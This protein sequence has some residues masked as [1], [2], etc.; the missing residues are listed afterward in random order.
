MEA[1]AFLLAGSYLFCF[2]GVIGLLAR[3]GGQTRRIDE[4]TR[5]IGLLK[6]ELRV[7]KAEPGETQTIEV[8]KTAEITPEAVRPAETVELPPQDAAASPEIAEKPT[9]PSPALESLTRFVRGG[10]LWAA[11]GILLLTAAF[12]LL[13]TYLARRGFFTVEMGIAAAALSGLAMLF[14][15]WRFRKRRALYFLL[16]QGGGIGILYL[17][18]FAAHKLTP[19]FPHV[20]ALILLSL[21]VAPAAILALLQNSQAL[22]V[23]GTAGGF[24]APLLL[25]GGSGNHVFLFAYYLALDAGVLAIGLRRLW[26]WLD[27]LSLAATF[28]VSL[29]W[30]FVEY[31]AGLFWTVEPFMLG[32][33]AVFTAL[34]L[35][36][37]GKDAPDS[38]DAALV[39]ATPIVGAAAQWR[40]FSF[41]PHGHAIICVAFAAAYLALAAGVWRCRGKFEGEKARPFA[42]GYLAFSVLLANLAVPLELRAEVTSAVWAAE[43]AVGFVFGRWRKDRKPAVAGAILHAASAAAF[44]IGNAGGI[45]YND[46]IFRSRQFIGAIVVS[47]AAFAMLVN[48]NHSARKENAQGRYR[49]AW[50][51][52]AW[53]FCWWFGAWIFEFCCVADGRFA[54][55]FFKGK[56]PWAFIFALCAITAAV[57]FALSRAFCC[58]HIN[59]GIAPS[60]L[61]AAGLVLSAIG[62]RTVTYF[63][64]W[65]SAIWTHNFFRGGIY[66]SV[67][68]LFCRSRRAH[69][70]LVQNR[71]RAGSF[72]ASRGV[73]VCR[74][75]HRHCRVK[76]ERAG[77]HRVSQAR[78]V[79]DCSGGNS[80]KPRP[81]R[82]DN[83]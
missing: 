17:S 72:N 67:A 20:P 29:V 52:A 66:F 23:L 60:L 40:V 79:L 13:I 4:L 64:F 19:Y 32:F 57:S 58:P 12:A 55:E 43:G 80:A 18:V 70:C 21:L 63:L 5:D 51:F 37:L 56:N 38:F 53:A 15:G 48:L 62:L 50:A 1:L 81:R 33:I 27:I 54:G 16:L 10:N 24:A 3:T 68:H 83:V 78:K 69:F 36:A 49:I 7:R 77:A 6:N 45:A 2:F 11:G 14:A 34:G 26:K 82:R 61:A 30:L 65:W 9:T 47:L 59:L 73:D 42:S 76:R 8:V 28:G 44:F 46:G 35:R 39:L 31:K 25:S 74:A 22:A 71:Q 75:P 41:V